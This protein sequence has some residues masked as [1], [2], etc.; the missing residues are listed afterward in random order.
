[1]R[2]SR[3]PGCIFSRPA[4]TLDRMDVPRTLAA[5]PALNRAAFGLNSLLRPEQARAG[6]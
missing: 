5:A 3:R 2:R 4:G 6:T 1:M